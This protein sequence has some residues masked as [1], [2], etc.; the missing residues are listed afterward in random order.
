MI[1]AF[2]DP[3][4]CINSARDHINDLDARLKAFFEGQRTPKVRDYD[5]DTGQD[6]YKV[7]LTGKISGKALTLAKNSFSDLRDALDHAVYASTVTLRPG[8]SPSRTAF[9]FADDAAG[10][11][12]KL[13]R[14]LI[15]VPPEIRSFLEGLCPHKTGNPLLWALNDTRNTKT[16]RLLVPLGAVAVG[17]EIKGSA[18]VIS[19]PARIGYTDWDPAKNE[20]E[21]ARMARGS[22]FDHE[23]NISF[24]VVFGDASPTVAGQPAVATLHALA[25]EVE[26]I[27]GA[28]E[29]ETER[30]LR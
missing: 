12:A 24:Q 23:V 28:I 3:R 6:V 2:D 15:D 22:T 10:V 1:E 7:R 27:V 30:L 11:H 17:H 14:K 21:Y 19:G 20:V 13:N 4:E 5:S 26:R 25:S 9:P 18:G 8:T 29:A 16:H